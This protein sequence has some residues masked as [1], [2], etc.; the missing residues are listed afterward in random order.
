MVID[1]NEKL[2]V[3]MD[4]SFFQLLIILTIL[5]FS[6]NLMAIHEIEFG[7]QS[8]AHANNLILSNP[9]LPMLYLKEKHYNLTMMPAIV[10]GEVDGKDNLNEPTTGKYDGVG[11]A[12]GFSYSWRDRWGFYGF[13]VGSKVGGDFTY[14]SGNSGGQGNS[15]IAKMRG[16]EATYLTFSAGLSYQFYGEKPDDFVMPIFIGPSIIK[17]KTKGRLIEEVNGTDNTDFDLEADA[18]IIGVLAGIQFGWT[19]FQN[20]RLVPFF[21]AMVGISDGCENYTVT[22]KRADDIL[23][24]NVNNQSNAT[25]SNDCG[26]GNSTRLIDAEQQIPFPTSFTTFGANLSYVPWGLTFNVTSALV[27]KIANLTAEPDGNEATVFSLSYTFSG[28]F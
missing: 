23:G 10:K 7:V 6:R 2:G 21:M 19:F 27:S 3:P 24:L 18:T 11:G 13:G 9:P 8:A 1:Q 25:S 4:R 14:G 28:N 15:T 16:V 22:N 26:T 17:S 12:L 20:W 5:A